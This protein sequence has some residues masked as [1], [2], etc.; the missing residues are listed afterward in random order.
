MSE[1]ASISEYIAKEENAFNVSF[2]IAF[3]NLLINQSR[4]SGYNG[5]EVQ[6]NN[7]KRLIDHVLFVLPDYKT[8]P[9]GCYDIGVVLTQIGD[10]MVE[11]PEQIGYKLVPFASLFGG[12][13]LCLDYRTN[14]S[15]PEIC[16]WYHEESDILNPKTEKVFDS[17]DS[18]IGIE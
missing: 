13:M 9:D 15:R 17:F 12:D 6:C 8:N 5:K 10:R 11:D 4:W 14:S 7:N 3:R 1:K 18:F 16:I 2:P